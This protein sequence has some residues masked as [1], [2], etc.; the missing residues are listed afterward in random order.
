MDLLDATIVN[1]ALPGI[2]ATTGATN[3][4][5]QWTAAGYALAFGL[6]LITGGRLGDIAGRKCLFLIGMG[7]FIL[8]SLACGLAPTPEFLVTARLAQ[9]AAAAVMVPQVLATLHAVFPAAERPK[10]FGLYGAVFGLAAVSGPLLG[11][12]I[13]NADIFGLSWR[14][15][16]LL[17]IPIGI[18]GMIAAARMIPETRAPGR[19][20]LDL[21]GVALATLGLLLL[22]L[23]LIQGPELGWPAWTFVSLLASPVVLASFVWHEHRVAD[24]AGTPLVPLA[25]FRAGPFSCGLLIQAVFQ[26]AIGLFFLTWMLYLQYGLGFSPLRAGLTA[27]PL[28]LGV[29]LAAG[30]LVP[31]LLPRL[32]RHVITLGAL[33]MASGMLLYL[34]A[35]TRHGIDLTTARM[36]PTLLLTG[37]G[38][39][40]TITPI[41]EVTLRPTPA[42]DSGS[43]SGV[44]N[45]TAQLSNALGAALLTVVALAPSSQ[46]HNPEAFITAFRHTLIFTTALLA[47]IALLALA[48]PP[49]PAPQDRS[50]LSI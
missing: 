33:V 36:I 30:G 20:T 12:L 34:L 37:I 25:L 6:L 13:V 11:A 22:T 50:G 5:L 35:A 9:G 32:D 45:T 48:L 14:P 18:V 2:Q 44:L 19:P 46:P 21:P 42:E 1:V 47:V 43:A 29:A 38:M 3:A 49:H 27:L 15:I 23:P 16:F 28:S 39:G 7:A 17:N 24:R 26:C 41:P 8:T 40:L 4:Q 31:R 10:A